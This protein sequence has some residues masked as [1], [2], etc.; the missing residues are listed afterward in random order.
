[1]ENQLSALSGRLSRLQETIWA[2]DTGEAQSE[3]AVARAASDYK[4]EM[5]YANSLHGHYRIDKA[6]F[7]EVCARIY[8]QKGEA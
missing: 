8:D 4:A 3:S 2:K 7:L 5:D 1:M 6:S